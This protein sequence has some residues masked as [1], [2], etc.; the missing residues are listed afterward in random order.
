MSHRRSSSAVFALVAIVL[1]GFALRASVLRTESLWRDE[2]DVIRFAF[3]PLSSLLTRFGGAAFNGPLYHLIMGGWLSLAGSSDIGLRYF[4]LVFGILLIVLIYAIARTIDGERTALL[5]VLIAALSPILIWYSGEG[6]MYTFQPA[7]LALAML[8]LLQ[9]LRP[10]NR[11][12]LW[13]TLFISCVIASFGAHILSPL[14]LAV[15]GISV[16]AHGRVALNRHRI[17]LLVSAAVLLLP[18]IPLLFTQFERFLS[19]V[20]LGHP[21]YPLTVMTQ[22]LL[23]NWTL[24]LNN[25]APVIISN[26]PPALVG[27]LRWAAVGLLLLAA[28]SGGLGLRR[29]Y[30]V[31]LLAWVALPVLLVFVISQNVPV[32]QPRYLLWSAPAFYIL[33]A[34]GVRRFGALERPALALI[35]TLFLL[36]FLGQTIFPIRPNLRAAFGELQPRLASGDVVVH[37]IPYTRFSFDYYIGIQAPAGLGF[38]DGPYTNNDMSPAE[39]ELELAPLL[40]APRVWLVEVTPEYWDKRGMVRSWMDGTFTLED[41]RVYHGVSVSLYRTTR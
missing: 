19:G 38:Q 17:G 24:G 3:E 37:Q 2:T 1:L 22:S 18:F 33:A 39:L 7:L 32:F 10:A 4:S 8:A 40:N 20:D 30:G 5:A 28:I 26:P 11:N 27:A 36:G 13:W 31:A 6:K 9:A 14:F 29:R 34:A 25:D 23:F 21:Y 35:A 41:R 16:L 15:A 12:A